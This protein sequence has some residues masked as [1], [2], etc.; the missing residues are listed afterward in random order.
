MNITDK[1][2]SIKMD[3]ALQEG[4]NLFNL[5]DIMDCLQRGEMQSH[6]VGDTWGITQVHVWPRRKSVNILF[7]VGDVSDLPLLE[8]KIEKW[9]K[10][11]GANVITAIGRDGWWKFRTSGWKKVGVMYSKDI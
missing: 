1:S 2:M 7:V 9:A 3:R 10:G 11:I 5:D 6:V 4:N 8:Q